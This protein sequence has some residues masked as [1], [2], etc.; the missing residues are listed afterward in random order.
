MA[1]SVQHRNGPSGLWTEGWAGLMKSMR[2]S[3]R[4]GSRQRTLGL[5]RGASGP[6]R[7][8]GGQG[9]R[10]GPAGA[11]A[12]PRSPGLVRAREAASSWSRPQRD[13]HE[14]INR[15]LTESSEPGTLSSETPD[16]QDS[17]RPEM[18]CPPPSP[19]TRSEQRMGGRE[20][21]QRGDQGPLEG[22]RPR[23]YSPRTASVTRAP[24]FSPGS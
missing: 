23:P 6:Q 22:D 20:E 24:N 21:A 3:G 19:Q 14:D 9:C 5:Q 1:R 2:T 13:R 16:S 8:R 17:Q 11:E 15:I 4:Q 10:R 7:R 12:L 18:P